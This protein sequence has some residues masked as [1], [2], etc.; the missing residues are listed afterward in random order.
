MLYI[1]YYYCILLR[2]TGF[3]GMSKISHFLCNT[4]PSNPLLNIS[5]GAPAAQ[6]KS[7]RAR[8]AGLEI[9][10]ELVFGRI[11]LVVAALPFLGMLHP[12]SALISQQKYN[13]FHMR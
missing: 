9:T 3:I 5:S 4:I 13:N 11:Q 12:Q 10:G 7:A 1:A 6:K 8:D 2:S